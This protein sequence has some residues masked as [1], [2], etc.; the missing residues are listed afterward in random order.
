MSKTYFEFRMKLLKVLLSF[1]IGKLGNCLF[2]SLDCRKC[3]KDCHIFKSI[4]VQ[5]ILVR[6]K[7]KLPDFLADFL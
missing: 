2:V 6:V 4:L 7:M 3:K 1:E 5:S